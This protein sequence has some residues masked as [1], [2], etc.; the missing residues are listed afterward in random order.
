[1]LP[2]YVFVN[3]YLVLT[4]SVLLCEGVA[5][6]PG[7]FNTICQIVY[8]ICGIIIASWWKER[9]D[10]LLNHVGL[11]ICSLFPFLQTSQTV[12]AATKSGKSGKSSA[13]I[14]WYVLI[15]FFIAT[16]PAYVTDL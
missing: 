4:L 16:L 11:L 13:K 7:R 1:V 2:E 8:F 6:I 12:V 15:L 3:L 5:Y 14:E 10:S 9:A